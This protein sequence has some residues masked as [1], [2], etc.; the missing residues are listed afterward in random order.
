MKNS[1]KRDI[2]PLKGRD[3]IINVHHW[4][5]QIDH[6]IEN[7]HNSCMSCS[8]TK[9]WDRHQTKEAVYRVASQ[10]KIG[11]SEKISLAGNIFLR[12]RG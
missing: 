5:I 10:L 3:L 6:I 12:G 7:K 9:K 1:A 4:G 8:A 2:R 11:V